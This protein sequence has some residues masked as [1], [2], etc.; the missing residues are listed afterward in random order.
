MPDRVLPQLI[1]LPFPY[2]DQLEQ[3]AST[4]Y[5]ITSNL[6][7][8]GPVSKT[9]DMEGTICLVDFGDIFLKKK[10]VYIF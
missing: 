3:G 2:I 5:S 10:F 8:G 9:L 7:G 6:V 1:M 4:L